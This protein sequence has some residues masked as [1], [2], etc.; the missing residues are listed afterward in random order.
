MKQ[1]IIMNSKLSIANK[2]KLLKHKQHHTEKHIKFM[3]KEMG[4]G[5]NFNQSHIKAMKNIGK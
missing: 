3:I 1:T 2:N 4:K 5:K